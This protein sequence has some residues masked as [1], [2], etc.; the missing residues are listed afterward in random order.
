MQV[1]KDFKAITSLA[2]MK[3]L[4]G[5]WDSRVRQLLTTKEIH[6]ELVR[7]YLVDQAKFFISKW[8]DDDLQN[9]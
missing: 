4:L 3:E 5:K 2:K 8:D 7:K 1:Y 6:S 9:K